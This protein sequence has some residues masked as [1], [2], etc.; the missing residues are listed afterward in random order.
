VTSSRG[1]VNRQVCRHKVSAAAT[2]VTSCFGNNST[3]R[4]NVSMIT[5]MY[6]MPMSEGRGPIESMD[7]RSIGFRVAGIKLEAR[8]VLCLASIFWRVGQLCTKCLTFIFWHV[9]QLSTKCL[10]SCR[11]LGHLVP[12]VSKVS[13]CVISASFFNP[14][15]CV[16]VRVEPFN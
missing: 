15:V 10:T 11:K 4:V 13:C 7:I 8:M 2:A 9:G 1:A 6:L 3:Y 16:K 12:S 14:P 5:I